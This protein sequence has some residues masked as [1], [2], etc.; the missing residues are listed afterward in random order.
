MMRRTPLF[1]LAAALVG[2]AAI[3]R[4]EERDDDAWPQFVRDIK[5][6]EV[7]GNLIYFQRHRERYRVD[8]RRFDSNLHH[9]SLQGNLEISSPFFADTAGF[10]LGAFATTDL[11]NSASPDHEISFFPWSDP[12]SADWSKKDADSGASL[13]RAHLKLRRKHENGAWWGKLG[14]FQPSGP[15]VMGVNWSL[16]PGSYLGAEGGI[17]QGALSLASAYAARYKAPWYR[18]TYAFREEDAANTKISHIWSVGA[19]YAFAPEASAE[20][21]Y[22]E[23]PGFLQSAH[24]KL[25]YRQEKSAG[26]KSPLYLSYQLYVMGDRDDAA[27][28]G[29]SNNHYAGRWAFQHYAAFAR[30]FSPYVLKGEFLHTRAPGTRDTHLGYFVYRLTG[31]YGG[32]NGAYEPWWDNR[33][34]WNHNRESAI[35]VS[36]SRALDDIGAAGVTATLSAARGWGGKAYG[37]R[38]T[39]KENAWSL[40]LTWIVPSGTLKNTRVT[41]HYTHYDNKTRLPSWTGYKNLF[42]DERDLKFFVIVPWKL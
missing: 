40:D 15:G 11:R 26:V 12:W 23:A 5:T 4:G 13:Y 24:L 42:Q 19:R 6:S 33:S 18:K 39:L 2:M 17:E 3:V 31:R 20:V 38:Q 41:L 21:A 10:E 28:S 25:K 22:G 30:E 34:D 29:Q 16:M 32:A 14:Y 1:L 27:F 7:S 37:V 8:E 9:Q 35:F 36:L